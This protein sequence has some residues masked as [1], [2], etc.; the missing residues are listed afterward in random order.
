M[1]NNTEIKVEKLKDKIEKRISNE[2]ILD[3]SQVLNGL[4][5]QKILTHALSKYNAIL[6]NKVNNNI[7]ILNRGIKFRRLFKSRIPNISSITPTI[8][9]DGSKELII[10]FSYN[11]ICKGIAAIKEDMSVDFEFL[12]GRF[13]KRDTVDFLKTNYINFVTYFNAMT[14]FQLEYPGF[15]YSWGKEGP[16]KNK[17]QNFN[18]GFVYAKFNLDD[19]DNTFI[20]LS[21]EDDLITACINSPKY[22][23]LYDYLDYY[24]YRFLSTLV[25]NEE[26]LNPLYK[27]IV[28]DSKLEKNNTIRVLKID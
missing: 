24:K 9:E 26:E 12:K 27:K 18:D 8:N 28:N 2:N 10:S 21:D 7:K 3:K 19:L 22:G 17:I 25:I 1:N 23:E 11:N 4:E 5:L 16:C 14:S 15:S 6:I 20:G 13:S